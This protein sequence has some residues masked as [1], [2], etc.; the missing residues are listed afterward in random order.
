[1]TTSELPAGDDGQSAIDNRIAI[2]QQLAPVGHEL[3]VVVLASW[4]FQAA[5]EKMRIG[6]VLNGWLGSL[7]TAPWPLPRLRAG[8]RVPQ[9]DA[10]CA[11]IVTGKNGRGGKQMRC[12]RSFNQQSAI[13]N[14]QS[15]C[16]SRRLAE[17]I[18]AVR[19]GERAV[20]L[21]R[22]LDPYAGV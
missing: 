22:H 13:D 7:L 2:H 6:G 10:C 14:R 5:V 9:A 21:H 20:R 3:R 19:H 11:I 16:A 15:I 4:V 8:P 1:M 17:P 12:I 18:P